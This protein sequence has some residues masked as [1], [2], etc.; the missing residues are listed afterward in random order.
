MQQAQSGDKVRVHYVGTLND[1]TEFDS[2]SERDPIEFTLGQGQVIAGFENAV[3]GMAPG[4]QKDVS[5]PAEDA[6]GPRHDAL[7][8][9]VERER[10]PQEIPLEIGTRLQAAGPG[11]QPL[12]LTVVE[13]DE[14]KVTLDANHPLAGEDLNFK[15]ELIEILAA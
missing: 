6:Y 5:I 12:Q 9:A 11:G 14:Q 13:L 4:E 15:L 8:Q 1:G 2:S 7:V 10:I 3:I